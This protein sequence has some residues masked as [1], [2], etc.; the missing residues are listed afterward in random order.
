MHHLAAEIKHFARADLGFDLVGIAPAEEDDD[1]AA[2]V[3]R[4]KPTRT[5]ADRSRLDDDTASP[6]PSRINPRQRPDQKPLSDAQ[7]RKMFGEAKRC[8]WETEVLKAR[9]H[10]AFGVESTKDLR[11][12]DF[13]QVLELIRRGPP[14]PPAGSEAATE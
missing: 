3:P 11:G 14:A 5:K 6:P 12:G 7:R 9:L 2:A 1:A 4:P 10:D 8:G 13:D